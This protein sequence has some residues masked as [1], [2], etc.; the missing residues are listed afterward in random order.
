MVW[1]MEEKKTNLRDERQREQ[2]EGVTGNADLSL[3][4]EEN[5]LF[6]LFFF[7]C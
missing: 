6:I 1:S 7:K 2:G 5:I 4:L 3:G